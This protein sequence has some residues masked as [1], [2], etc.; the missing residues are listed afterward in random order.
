MILTWYR[1]PRWI[2]AITSIWLVFKMNAIRSCD[3]PSLNLIKISWETNLDTG[4]FV[5]GSKLRTAA[6][7]R[8]VA[9]QDVE[10][11]TA[12]RHVKITTCWIILLEGA[13]KWLISLFPYNR[14]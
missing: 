6:A 9:S 2:S 12:D 8:A 1:C 14:R 5:D 10:S 3:I 7:S 4:D 11:Q 13:H